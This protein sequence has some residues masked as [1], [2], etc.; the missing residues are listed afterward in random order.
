MIEEAF[1]PCAGG[2]PGTS[3]FDEI[4]EPRCRRCG[5]WIDLAPCGCGERGHEV[6]AAAFCST[7]RNRDVPPNKT[8]HYIV[9]QYLATGNDHWLA[10]AD[11]DDVRRMVMILADRLTANPPRGG[12]LMIGARRLTRAVWQLVLDGV[13][14]AR[15]PAGDACLDLRD[16]ID[17]E[18]WPIDPLPDP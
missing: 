15:S 16:T 9:S 7:E 12:P 2:H 1:D 10:N 5:R 8:P 11:P 17:T 4:G 6:L 14:D 13:V 18:W 3:Y